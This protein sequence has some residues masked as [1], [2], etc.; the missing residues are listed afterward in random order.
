MSEERTTNNNFGSVVWVL[1]LTATATLLAVKYAAAPTIPL[2]VCLLP[3]IPIGIQLVFVTVLL[4]FMLGC[5]AL[6][7]I[8]SLFENKKKPAKRW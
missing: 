8:V 1:C 6:A 3:L 5:F 4:I 2:W 7:G